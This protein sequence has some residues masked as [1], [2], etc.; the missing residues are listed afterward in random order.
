MVQGSVKKSKQCRKVKKL[1][2]FSTRLKSKKLLHVLSNKNDH[3]IW[4][5]VKII[6]NELLQAMIDLRA[7]DNY[8]SHEAVHQLELISQQQWVP[9]QVYMV[10]TSSM[11]VWNYVHMKVIVE[12]VSQKLTFD[13]LNIKYDTILEMF[14]L[15]NRNSKIDWIN[16]KLCVIEHTYEIS[17]Q[18]KMCL[19]EHKLW[20]YE[21]LFLEK[22]QSR[23][24][25]L[26]FM[27][28]D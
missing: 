22:E 8:I 13:I 28:K 24:M 15:H 12:D 11:I 2:A 10:N 19:S 17:E 21:I 5:N 27:S 9:A 7:T 18:S 4:V 25:L 14:W 26:Y 20:D 6:S 16:K 1:Q 3:K 23:W